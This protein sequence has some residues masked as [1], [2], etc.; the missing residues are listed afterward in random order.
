MN[1]RSKGWRWARVD[2]A[3]LN[4]N[5]CA[6]QTFNKWCASSSPSCAHDVKDDVEGKTPT[7]IS[8]AMNTIAP[9]HTSTTQIYLYL[10]LKFPSF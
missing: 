7:Q 4:T 1:E 9:P 2:E 10:D 5:P 6:L 3:Y 8:I